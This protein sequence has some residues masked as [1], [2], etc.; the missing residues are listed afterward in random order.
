MLGD[1]DGGVTGLR[2]RDTQTG[3]ESEFA[4]QGLFIAIGHEPN[5]QLFREQLPMNEVA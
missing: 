1:R 3:A 5:T 4:T 2:L